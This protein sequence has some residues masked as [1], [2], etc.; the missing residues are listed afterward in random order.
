V[1]F[2]SVFT[3]ILVL[4]S[5]LTIHAIRYIRS[6]GTSWHAVVEKLLVSTI[7]AARRV[8]E[9]LLL[10]MASWI[11]AIE[12]ISIAIKVH[13]YT[14]ICLEVIQHILYISHDS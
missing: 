4:L 1:I 6:I 7:I 10:S 5:V 11:L 8:L 9:V 13:L 14:R 2:L 3:S 12:L